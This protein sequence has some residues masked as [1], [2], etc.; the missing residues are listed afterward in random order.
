MV[1]SWTYSRAA[2]QWLVAARQLLSERGQANSLGQAELTT[3]AAAYLVGQT[4][5]SGGDPVARFHLDNGARL[6]CLNIAGDRSAKGMKQSHGLMVNYL[7][8]LDR[9]ESHHEDFTRGEIAHSRAVGAC[10]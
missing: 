9:I 1:G 8:D 10:L 4:P 2:R 3:L 6:E 5:L 7:D